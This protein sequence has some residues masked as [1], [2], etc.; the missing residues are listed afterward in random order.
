MQ[1]QEEIKLEVRKLQFIL[2]ERS[3]R[4]QGRTLSALVSQSGSPYIEELSETIELY[5]QARA[6]LEVLAWILEERSF[7]PS[8][9]LGDRM[10][11]DW[12]QG[13]PTS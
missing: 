3:E 2:Q 5:R 10:P 1:T 13:D 12:K 11:K 8:D 9:P 7:A 6:K 4:A